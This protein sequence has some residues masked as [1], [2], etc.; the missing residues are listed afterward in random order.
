MD[1][2]YWRRMKKAEAALPEAFLRSREKFCVP[3]CARFVHRTQGD[4][5]WTLS[6]GEVTALL[7]HCHRS[8]FPVF[9]GLTEIPAPRFMDRFLRKI[10]I[11]AVQGSRGDTE[12]LETIMA[13]LGYRKTDQYDYDLMSLDRMPEP[14]GL[15]P[16]L[17]FRRPGMIDI[18]ALTPLQAAYEQ[19]EVLPRG[20]ILN[21]AA[22]R[23]SL[24]NIVEKE[25][26]LIAELNGRIVGKIN[27]NAKSFTRWQIG[28]VYVHPDYR[29][30]GIAR[31][32][33]AALAGELIAQGKQ[34]SLFVK[35]RN[36]AARAVY[37][38]VG[39]EVNGDYRIS[40]F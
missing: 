8:L 14:A 36:A 16:G 10:P 34:V 12:I 35:K 6:R 4:H 18:E 40:Y 5:V 28:G 9:N 27:T 39:F 15:P 29:G 24:I 13:D 37:R 11:H 1:T 22:P 17:T 30:Q 2:P 7:L 31:G 3:A 19:E 25:R 32:M 21:P 26:I 38:R 20:A 23:L 33:T